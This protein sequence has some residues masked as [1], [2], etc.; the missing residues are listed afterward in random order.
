[1]KDPGVHSSEVIS[2]EIHD[3]ISEGKDEVKALVSLG[4]YA[5]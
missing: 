1:M 5:Y 4:H 2:L 3:V